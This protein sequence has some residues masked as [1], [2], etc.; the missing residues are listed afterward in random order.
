MAGRKL[1]GSLTGS[2]QLVKGVV[3]HFL[4]TENETFLVWMAV[5]RR[6]LCLRGFYLV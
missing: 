3:T 4:R 6:R 1:T 2:P 5:E